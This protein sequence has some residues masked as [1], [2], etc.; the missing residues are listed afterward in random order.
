MS[1]E[2]EWDSVATLVAND[3]SANRR[4]TFEEVAASAYD[5]YA[6]EVDVDAEQESFRQH[7]THPF[8]FY[9]RE[10]LPRTRF[11]DGH[12]DDARASERPTPSG[13]IIL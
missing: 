6:G 5:S 10:Q 9:E 3:I 11:G 7:V 13:S 12:S 2:Q 4:P 1:A 8:G